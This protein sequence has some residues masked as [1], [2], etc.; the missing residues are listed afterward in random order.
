MKPS[1][2]SPQ[3]G[4]SGLLDLFVILIAVALVALVGY[5]V[6]TRPA[7]RKSK[8]I[9]CTN[10][11]KQIGLSFRLWAS[12]NGDKMPAQVS[13][14]SGG[15]MELVSSGL[16]YP[17]FLVMSNELGSPQLLRCFSDLQRQAAKNFASL[18][19]SNISY[20]AVPEADESNPELWLSGDRNLA[21]NNI[22]LTAGL[23]RMPTNQ[24][25]SWTT[26]LHN[27]AGNLCFADGSVQQPSSTKLHS[28]ATNA[29]RVHFATTNT[30][31][32]LAIP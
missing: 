1:I 8:R 29:L 27:N 24:F 28:Y 15:T 11:Q 19:D 21:T 2:S 7:Q 4:E 18:C 6:I 14:N 25:I 23:F 12:D 9:N 26:Q 16:V 17:H 20:F 30:S 3:R 10:L 31:F 22:G 5:Y 32:R 13:T